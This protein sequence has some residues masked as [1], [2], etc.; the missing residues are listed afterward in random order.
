MQHARSAIG[1]LE[2]NQNDQVCCNRSADLQKIGHTRICRGHGFAECALSECGAETYRR[3]NL[4]IN[5]AHAERGKVVRPF[6]Q[7]LAPELL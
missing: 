1:F 4:T 5:V 7:Q 6:G 2:L 3:Q